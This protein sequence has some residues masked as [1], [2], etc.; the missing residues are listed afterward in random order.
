M[1]QSRLI[2]N[3]NIS[4]QQ[5][6]LFESL[7]SGVARVFPNTHF[8]PKMSFTP[9][10]PTLRFRRKGNMDL[11]RDWTHLGGSSATLGDGTRYQGVIFRGIAANGVW[12]RLGVRS[13]S[14]A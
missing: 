7:R 13:G 14:F 8:S 3:D 12:R 10:R 2:R 9:K 11:T 1:V 5:V 6:N 4:D